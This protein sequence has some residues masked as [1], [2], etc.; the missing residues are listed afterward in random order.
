MPKVNLRQKMD[1][2]QV[3]HL[4]LASYLPFMGHKEVGSRLDAYKS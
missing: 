1:G 3:R 4:Q 2:L